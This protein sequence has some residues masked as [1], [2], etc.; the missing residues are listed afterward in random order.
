VV[1]RD[2][3][4]TPVEEWPGLKV[5]GTIVGGEVVHAAGIG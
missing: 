5:S 3:A 4:S 1:E 2:L